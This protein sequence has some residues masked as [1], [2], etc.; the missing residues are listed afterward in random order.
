MNTCSVLTFLN[1]CATIGEQ[2]AAL[3]ARALRKEVTHMEREIT[4]CTEGTYEDATLTVG[5]TDLSLEPE[6]VW[7]TGPV[8]AYVY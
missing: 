8:R 1:D 6:P 7:N 5:E 4:L 3:L 2:G